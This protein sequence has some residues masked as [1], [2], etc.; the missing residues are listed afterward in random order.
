MKTCF[1]LVRLYMQ[2]LPSHSSQIIQLTE[3]ESPKKRPEKLE[4]FIQVLDEEICNKGDE[5]NRHG[6]IRNKLELVA[7]APLH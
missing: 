5:R 7:T 6:G 1:L 3:L 4:L 2:R